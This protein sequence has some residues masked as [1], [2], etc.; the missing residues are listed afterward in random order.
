MYNV[1]INWLRASSL[2]SAAR[3]YNRRLGPQLRHDY[4]AA[5]FYTADQVKAAVMRCKLP[6]NALSIG[7]AAFLTEA[8]F[9]GLAGNE[10]YQ[11]LRSLF[12]RFNAS[13]PT[14]AFE[15]APE[16]SDV[17]RWGGTQ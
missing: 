14:S 13:K 6:L 4:G 7:Y 8:E 3:M 17:T 11:S 5:E 2:K 1:F 9:A 15:P 12:M 16:N 10:D